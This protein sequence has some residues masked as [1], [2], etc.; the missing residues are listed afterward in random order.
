MFEALCCFLFITIFC[1]VWFPK[2]IGKEMA[3]V[4]SDFMEGWNSYEK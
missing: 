4:Y 3:R 1:I 2:R